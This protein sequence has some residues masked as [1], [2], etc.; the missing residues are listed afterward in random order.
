MFAAG[1]VNDR[2]AMMP[3][4]APATLFG[5]EWMIDLITADIRNKVIEK[6]EPEK[7]MNMGS[8]GKLPALTREDR[9]DVPKGLFGETEQWLWATNRCLRKF[10]AGLRLGKFYDKPDSDRAPGQ[11]P[12]AAESEPEATSA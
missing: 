7:I 5:E 9:A 10:N 11:F 4:A 2:L 8:D 12:V 3:D 6:I 1:R